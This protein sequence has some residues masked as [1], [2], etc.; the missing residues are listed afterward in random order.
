[1]E[2][3]RGKDG[4]GMPDLSKVKVA[5]GSLQRQMEKGKEEEENQIT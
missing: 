5:R 2:K 3:I 4:V 1:M